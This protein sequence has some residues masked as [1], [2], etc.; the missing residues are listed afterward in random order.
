MCIRDSPWGGRL[1]SRIGGR[2]NRDGTVKCAR[3]LG[4]HIG[5]PKVEAL[6]FAA[7]QLSQSG[8]RDH[9]I[10]SGQ[11]G[12]VGVT[13]DQYVGLTGYGQM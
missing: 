11:H 4:E 6:T 13:T 10:D 5:G 2:V 3:G 1:H 7:E 12:Q 9:R 8:R